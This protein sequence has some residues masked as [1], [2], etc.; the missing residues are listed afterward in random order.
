MPKYQIHRI[1]GNAA[2][3]IALFE[4]HG[5]TWEPLGRP[6]DGLLFFRGLTAA[7]ELKTPTGKLRP[8]QV[9]FFARHEGLTAVIRTDHEALRLLDRMR[10]MAAAVRQVQ[11][12]S[13]SATR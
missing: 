6:V 5:A 3:L 1:D 11:E 10:N 7:V 12:I 9:K 2:P 8:L 13:T 4:A